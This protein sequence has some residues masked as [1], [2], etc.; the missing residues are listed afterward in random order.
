MGRP[1]HW[2]E[3]GE[4]PRDASAA[5]SIH[6]SATQSISNKAKPCQGEIST[7][8]LLSATWQQGDTSRAT[9]RCATC[10]GL[11]IPCL[12][13]HEG[14]GK[15]LPR[16]ERQHQH[17]TAARREPRG[18]D[19]TSRAGAVGLG[20]GPGL[21]L[22]LEC[23]GGMSTSCPPSLPR[24]ETLSLPPAIQKHKPRNSVP[25]FQGLCSCRGAAVREPTLAQRRI[26]A[27]EAGH[28]WKSLSSV[29]PHTGTHAPRSAHPI[30]LLKESRGRWSPQ[31]SPPYQRGGQVAICSL[32]CIFSVTPGLPASCQ[33]GP[34]VGISLPG[35][36]LPPLSTSHLHCPRFRSNGDAA[37]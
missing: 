9:L 10:K 26:S 36:H 15:T 31:A 33:R 8:H 3:R 32:L 25:N 11:L 29:R 2:E 24:W 20:P 16:E 5:A 34:G 18:E 28:E 13:R 7:P 27:A 1:L 12:V 22:L 17:P 23:M 6:P 14:V 37:D 21:P 4:T 35:L 19:V 30:I